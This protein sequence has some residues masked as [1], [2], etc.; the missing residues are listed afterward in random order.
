ML[1][2][3][4]GYCS[5]VVFD[6]AE[7]GTV[8]PTQQHH[9]QLAAIAQNHASHAPIPAPLLSSSLSN[10][11][12]RRESFSSTP[13]PRSPSI[14]TMRHSPA[15][16]RS[17]REGS[18]SS[19]V[20]GLGPSQSLNLPLFVAPSS[21]SSS[22]DHVIP[23]PGEEAE[24]YS[25][26]MGHMGQHHHS[27]RSGSESSASASNMGGGGGPS[28]LSG[29]SGEQAG[30]EVYEKRPNSAQ[31]STGQQDGE[32]GGEGE[33]PKKKRRVVLTHLGSED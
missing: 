31:G 8:H 9:R 1:A 33:Q 12:T 3:S 18:T 5:I 2:S 13:A 24:M 16:T 30:R 27:A 28:S 4:D 19:S 11:G 26:R 20:M 32:T 23:T 29:P 17:E 25:W 15:P 7:L 21:S 10:S 22:T 6:L 14:S